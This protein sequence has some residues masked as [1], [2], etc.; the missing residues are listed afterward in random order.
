MIAI[1]LPVLFV[2]METNE[3]S[4]YD[5]PISIPGAIGASAL[6]LGIAGVLGF[7]AFIMLRFAFTGRVKLWA[8]RRKNDATGQHQS[9][10]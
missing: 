1:G 7:L 6:I 4:S 3:L 2:A 8:L 9:S 10:D 5:V